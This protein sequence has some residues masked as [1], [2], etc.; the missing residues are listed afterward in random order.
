MLYIKRLLFVALILWSATVRAQSANRDPQ[1]GYLYPAGVQQ[2]TIVKIM[3][4]GQFLRGATDVYVTGEGVH[5]KVIKYIRPIGNLDKSQR[6]LLQ[7]RLAEVRDKRLAEL[8]DQVRNQINS[9]P[10]QNKKTGAAKARATT[11][12]NKPKETNGAK[13]KADPPKTEEVKLPDHPLLYD[14]ENKSLR[15]LAHIRSVFFS[16]RVKKQSN[17]QIAESVWIEIT[18]D[19]QAKPGNRE[20][21]ILTSTGLTNPMVFQVGT[22]PEVTELEPNNQQ[23][24]QKRPNQPNLLIPKPLDLPVL[25]NGQIMP[26][27][28]DRFRFRA[29]RGQ[30]LVIETCARSLIPYLADAVPGWFQATLALYDEMGKEVAFTDDY[31]FNPDPVLFYRVPQTGEYELEIRDSIYRG[32]EDFVYRVA[33]GEQS[34][35]TQVFPLGGRVG[36]TTDTIVSGWNLPETRL[37]LETKSAEVGFHQTRW[38]QGGKISNSILY[39][40]DTLDEC[41]DVEANNTTKDAQEIVLP[42]IINGRIDKPGDID[43]FKIVGKA[44]DKIVAEVYA[45]R[46][47]SPLDSLLRITDQSGNTIQLNDDYAIKDSYLH[48]NLMGMVTHHADSYLMTELKQDGTYYVHLSDSQQHG[49]EAFGYRLR[50]SAPQPD[51]VLRVTPSSLSVRAGLNVPVCAYLLRRDGF[52]GPVDVVLKDAPDGFKLYGGR[53][54]AGR[55]SVRLTIYVPN[56]APDQPL[57]LQLQ[58]QA[59]IGDR[60][61]SHTGYPA[62]NVMQAFLYRHLVSSQELLVVVR[63]TKWRT[64]PIVLAGQNDYI[65]I[66]QGGSVQ[67]RMKTPKRKVLQEML[68]Q[69][70]D[71][72][73]GVSLNNMRV[74]PQGLEFN[75]KVDKDAM[76]VGFEDNLIVEA[77]REY[78]PTQKNGKPA[79]MKRRDSMGVFPAIPIKI[80]Q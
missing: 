67:V 1:I 35:I 38:Q 75:L 49:G 68:L 62:E 26:G 13:E 57:A 46:L 4:G 19:P 78:L 21:R 17:R 29:Q 14:L 55:D 39:A 71:P 31:R 7:Q 74:I 32:R 64:P 48:K 56:D 72:P 36:T 43:V 44:G 61:V 20:L 50:I 40:V 23:A 15:E 27:D 60:T 52:T 45:R 37:S 76:P 70:N 47:N 79:T 16:P 53:I 66:P 51:F 25:L 11:K 10:R 33:V 8:P 34:F 65:R 5:A 3:A 58:G 42:K 41:R 22:M 30:Q 18:V 80:V 6:D 2:G 28:V 12:N 77:F 9:T 73:K 59:L 63:K 24:Y 69:L 54:P